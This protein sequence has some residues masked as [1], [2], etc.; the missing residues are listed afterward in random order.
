M[1]I[2]LSIRI[3]GALREGDSLA[4]IGGDEF[5]AILADLTNA[6]TVE[7]CEP[8]LERLLLAASDPVTVGDIVLNVLASIGV[9]IYPQ[10][11]VDADQLVRHTDQAV[12]VAKGSVTGFEALIRWQHP[13]RGLLNPIDFLPVIE[14]N[15]M[16]IEM[17]EWVIDTAL[18]QIG[19]WQTMGL[20]LPVSTSVNIAAVQL[21]QAD[22]TDRLSMLLAA[23]P[24]VNP[25]YLE[26]EMLEIV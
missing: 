24:N 15:P 5:V 1:L 12:Y 9:T 20:N 26:L 2:A 18:T 3:K 11:N 22:F 17:G 21:Q 7:D 14:N 4:R 25:H 10:D 16:S 8:V 6:T 19:Q 23:H 13:E